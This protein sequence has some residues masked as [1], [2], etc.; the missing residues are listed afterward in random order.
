M[1][2]VAVSVIEFD[3][4]VQLFGAPVI[5]YSTRYPVLVFPPE[6]FGSNHVREILLAVEVAV[7]ESGAEG[8][9]IVPDGA[10]HCA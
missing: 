3:A 7:I 10:Y 4:T 2:E 8:T 5:E 1:Y 9:F 6:A